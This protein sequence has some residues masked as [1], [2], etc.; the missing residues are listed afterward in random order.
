MGVVELSATLSLFLLRRAAVA[1][2]SVVLVASLGLTALQ[3]VRGV[4]G[5]GRGA[6]FGWVLLGA[7][8]VY[9]RRLAKWGVLS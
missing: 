6:L 4:E 2:F 7:V 5:A 1:L 8:I 9:T 3:V